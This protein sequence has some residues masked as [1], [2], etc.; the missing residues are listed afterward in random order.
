MTAPSYTT[1]L[2]TFDLCENAGTYGEFTGMAD[3]GTPDSTDTDDPIQGTYCVSAQCSLKVGELQSIYA[4]YGSG[5][6]VPTD[7]A[8][9]VW[10]KFDAGGVLN[11]Y[12]NGGVRIVVGQTAGDWDAWKAAGVDT[13]P[14]PY[15]GWYNFAI[16]PTARTYDYQYGSGMGTTY[17]FVGMAISLAAVGPTK[18]QPY[19]VDAM[20][21]G[22]G[23][24]IIEYGSSGDGYANFDD[25]ATVND[26]NSGTYGYN[27]WG[28]FQASAGGYLWKGR[29]Q[30]GT[31]S[32]AVEF[33]DSNVFILI[34]D[35]VN[36][37]ANFN[38]IEINHASSIINWT[39]IVFKA[40][41]TTSPGRLV[42]N[43]N[44]DVNG[45]G[46]Q[47][48]DMGAFSFGGTGTELLNSIWNGCG[49]ITVNG[50]KINGSKISDANI[51]GSTSDLGAVD[52]DLATDPDG[53]L[54]NLEIT[55]GSN[56]YHA[57]NFGSS[58][59]STMTIRGLVASGFNAANNNY[60]STFYF[61]DTSGTFT[62]NCVGCSGN[63]TYKS[64]GCTVNIVSD[65]VTVKVTVKTAGGTVIENARVLVKAS[66]GAGPFPFEESVTIA[67]SGTTATV[68]HTGHG[69]A[70]NDYVVIEGASLQANNG[71][72]QITVNSVDEYEYTMASSP[73]S[74]PTGTITSTFVA[75][76]GLTSALGVVSTS[77]VYSTDQNVTGWAR[78]SSAT[79]L[80]KTGTI[81]DTIDSTDGLNYTAVMILD[82]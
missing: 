38:T 7:G 54:D 35:V 66:D 80:Y 62:L 59:P 30:L 10:N 45:D 69:M 46:C 24:I 28:L 6:T 11:N 40:L 4:D 72:F 9:L 64:A 74:S 81:S 67:N 44:A 57:I 61:E 70:T 16:N 58:I 71:V 34:D 52:W 25:A 8:I 15:G 77:R 43:H 33:V 50:G 76:Y 47:F 37:T 63:M 51:D 68:S 18:G 27:K 31:S 79:P 12:T 22:R 17:R 56:T 21:Y 82:E 53:Y 42:M 55:K 49:Q 32:N 48:F 36:C 20:R 3:G 26:D 73:G 1:D 23:S 39:N 41:G 14:Y 29:M 2:S 13:T 19:K 65:P 78:K 60:D 5:V 75:L